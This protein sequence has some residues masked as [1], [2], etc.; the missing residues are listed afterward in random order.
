LR[1]AIVFQRSNNFANLSRVDPALISTGH[2]GQTYLHLL[3]GGARALTFTSVIIVDSCHLVEPK[4]A[5]N[6]KPVKAISG[7]V[8]EGEWERLVG[9][10]GMVIRERDFKAQLF[11]D[12]LSFTTAPSTADGNFF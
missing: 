1:S 4:P 5:P 7:A 2:L 3:R 8:I 12:N 6:S 10:I 9:A 11:K